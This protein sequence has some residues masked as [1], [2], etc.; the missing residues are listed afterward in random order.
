MRDDRAD[1]SIDRLIA[2][3]GSLLVELNWVEW[4]NTHWVRSP[5]VTEIA[6]GRLLLD[7]WGTDWDADVGFPRERSVRLGFRRY[8]LG[9]ALAAE[10][11]LDQDRYTIDEGPGG[12]SHGPLT[13]LASALE[14]ASR[15]AAAAMPPKLVIPPARS[16]AK[17][18]VI[19]AVILIGALIA[20][21]VA[22]FTAEHFRPR[23]VQ[24]LDQ[25]PPMP[26]PIRPRS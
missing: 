7:L 17:S 23:P 22:T 20:I 10:I 5:R 24:Q 26:P 25:I 13:E 11:Y 21:A 3:D 8:H 19:V 1:A 15:R 12:T 2:P 9:G 4:F 14:A 16:S 6:T 18:Y